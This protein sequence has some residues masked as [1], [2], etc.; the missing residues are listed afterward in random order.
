MAERG[1]PR[2]LRRSIHRARR[3]A[4]SCR[5]IRR[6]A[7][8]GSPPSR[9]TVLRRLTYHDGRAAGS[10]HL[11]ARPRR[12]RDRLGARRAPAAKGELVE[13]VVSLSQKP[14]ATTS[15]R[16]GRQL[17]TRTLANAQTSLARAHRDRGPGRTDPLALPPGRER[18]GRRR[19]PLPARPADLAPGRRDASTRASATGRSSIA[20]RSRSVLPPSGARAHERRPGDEDR[21]HRRGDRPDA[22]VLLT[23]PGTRCP[24]GIPRARR[25]TRRRR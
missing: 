1:S 10:D 14:L 3:I 11:L 15:W 19:P 20:A 12:T 8:S 16:A 24:P 17:Q 7:D 9:N 21:D 5:L 6:C 18:D 4:A 2:P 23:R 13:V 25:T 22:P